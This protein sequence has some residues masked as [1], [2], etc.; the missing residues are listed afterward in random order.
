MFDGVP[1]LTITPW[2]QPP[3][4]GGRPGGVEPVPIQV[5]VMVDDSGCAVR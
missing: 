2:D 3:S 5:K 1:H 4:R